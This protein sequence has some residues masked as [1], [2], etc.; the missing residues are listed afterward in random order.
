[1]SKDHNVNAHIASLSKEVITQLT[2]PVDSGGSAI[3]PAT[4][5]DIASIVTALSNDSQT[6]QLVDSNGNFLYPSGE[7]VTDSV[8]I[9]RPA[10]TT[11]YTALDNIGT[12]AANVAQVDTI[13]L[14]G[15][16]P[17]KQVDTI[18]LIGTNGT[19]NITGTGGLTKEVIF[20]T[21]GTADLTQTATDFVTSWAADYL[22]EG[23]V[24][25]SSGV[26]II[27]TS[28]TYGIAFTSPVITN[29]SGDLDGSVV[30]TQANVVVGE[31][32]ITEIGTLTKT[33]TF[34]T[35]GTVDLTQTTADFVTA[36][37]ANYAAEGI[38]LTSSGADLIFTSD[39]AGVPFTSPVITNTAGDL[40]GTV[41][42]TTPNATIISFEIEN[43]AIANGG[44]GV[45]MDVKLDS[46]MTNMAS[47]D[48]RLWVFNEAPSGLV[49]DNVA[50][51]TAYANK[52]KFLFFV[53]VTMEA[54]QGSSDNVVGQASV[55]KEYKCA[56]TSLFMLVQTITGFTPTSGGKLDVMFNCIKLS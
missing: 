55:V 32:T 5:T 37:E 30:N 44:G 10:N 8:E 19:A 56:D 51:A 14:T 33:V 4:S 13:T 26:D 48:V 7:P 1:M 47:T 50:F 16:A 35:T 12:Y 38:T 24:V 25:T 21:G 54:Q 42:N 15:T 45:L 28:S 11:T 39:T 9:T 41:A 46:N 18:T 29:T 27:F 34:A 52:D 22:T 43:M 40:D 23:V 20:A 36:N 49:G 17:E 53:D 2:G 3:D 31:A 6:T